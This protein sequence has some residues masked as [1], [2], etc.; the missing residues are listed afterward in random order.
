MKVNA[1]ALVLGMGLILT[2]S[3]SFAAMDDMKA[4]MKAGMEDSMDAMKP[5]AGEAMEQAAPAMEAA[6]A[7]MEQAGPVDVGNKI[8]PI[9]GGKVGEG[10]MA[11]KEV[12]V[13]YNGKSYNLCC[14]MCK[15]EFDKD[16]A[17]YSK[18]VDDQMAQN[19]DSDGDDD[20]MKAMEPS[21]SMEQ[22]ADDDALKAQADAAAAK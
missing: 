11:G 14:A 7:A 8:C 15:A 3:Q 13:V 6:G 12:K 1:V 2:G 5:A 22:T 4:D 17:K 18:M 10:D 21:P 16:P 9:E 20:A 19:T